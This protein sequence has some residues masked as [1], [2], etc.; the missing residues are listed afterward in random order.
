MLNII[1]EMLLVEAEGH[2]APGLL[3]ELERFRAN[4]RHLCEVREQGQAIG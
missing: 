1:A 3:A 4:V 2:R